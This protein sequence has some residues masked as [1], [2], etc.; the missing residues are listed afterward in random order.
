MSNP[1]YRQGPIGKDAASAVSKG[2][3]VK[4]TAGGKVEHA[5]ATGAIFGAIT[6][7][8]DPAKLFSAVDVAV[9]YGT[10]VVALSVVEDDTID[11]GAAVFAAADGQVASTGTVQVGVAHIASADGFVETVLNNLPV[12]G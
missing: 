5:G 10:A 7:K 12:A 6:E 1:I 3:L 8:A 9:H 2:R 4:L 11:A